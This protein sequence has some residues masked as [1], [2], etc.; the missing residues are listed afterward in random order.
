MNMNCFNNSC[1]TISSNYDISFQLNY[2][3]A[4]KNLPSMQAE[5]P[6]AISILPFPPMSWRQR[7]D[8]FVDAASLRIPGKSSFGAKQTIKESDVLPK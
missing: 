8:P 3:V 2:V 5:A 7:C 4:I 1:T 6:I